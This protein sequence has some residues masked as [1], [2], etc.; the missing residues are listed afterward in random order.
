[1]ETDNKPIC[2]YCYEEFFINEYRETDAATDN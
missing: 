1:M 2:D